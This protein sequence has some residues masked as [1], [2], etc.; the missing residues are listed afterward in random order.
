MTDSFIDKQKLNNFMWQSLAQFILTNRLYI[1]ISL[2]AYTAF[3]GYHAKDAELS[4][5]FMRIVPP[6]DP[7][8]IYFKQFQEMFGEDASVFAIG[9]KDSSI[10][11]YQSFQAF[12]EF[13]Q[14]VANAN[15]IDEVLALPNLVTLKKDVANKKFV[16]HRIFEPF[17]QNQ[18][19]LDSLLAYVDDLGFYDDRL[20][21]KENGA[22]LMLISMEDNFLNSKRRLDVID[23]VR[24]AGDAFVQETGIGI[25]YAGLPYVRG[26]V[27]TK[28]KKE[29]NMFLI[30]S[31]CVTALVFFL[32]FRSF[33][34]VIFSLCVIGMVVISTVGC[35]S[36]LGYRITML[37][38]LLPPILVVIGVPNCIYLI[39]KFHQEFAQHNDKT[40]ALKNVIMKVGVVTLITNTTTAIGFAV[41]VFTKIGVMQEFGLVAT[42]NIFATF[43]ISILFIPAVFSYRPAPQARHMRHLQFYPVKA[44]LAFIDEV[45][46]KRYR[47]AVYMV[48]AALVVFAYIGTLKVQS[49]AYLVDDMPEESD[50]VKDLKFFE[51]NFIGI[52]PL[53]IVVDTGNKRGI[54]NRANLEKIEELEMYL[55]ALEN[56]SEPISLITF[57]KAANQAYFNNNPAEYRLPARRDQAFLQP[58]LRSQ[59]AENRLVQSYVDTAGQIVRV[60]L[61]V[62]DMGSLKMQQLIDNQIR[63]AIDSIFKDTSMDVKVTGTT[64]L[65]IRGTDYLINNLL[66][67]MLIAFGLIALIM[68]GLFRKFR[69]ILISL[70]PNMIP[71]LMTAGL[72]GYLGISL[73]PSTALVF[74][75]T[76]GIAVDDA[77]HFLAKYRQELVNHHFKVVNAISVSIRETGASMLYT[78][79]VLFFGFIIFTAS[80]FGG[81]IALGALTST[82]L[83]IAMLTNIVLLPCLLYSFDMNKEEL[84]FHPFFEH[85]EENFYHEDEDEEINVSKLQVKQ[86][87][88]N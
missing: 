38:G 4:Y 18:Q 86:P 56:V 50:V 45:V 55:S 85:L 60:S 12:A 72:M 57:L 53:E 76:F 20:I 16:P 27:Q 51:E 73:K 8:Y 15:G 5:D 2:F 1:I 35:I 44:F 26:I 42:I 47:V 88:K 63:P 81:T 87:E 69:I 41:L 10:Y 28:V 11:Q 23:D 25:H 9:I 52:M 74:S 68:G 70:I 49:I 29:L 84:K 61:N 31:L 59:E 3:M 64:L 19:E 67:S 62:A 30:I 32:F 46:V 34:P 58:Y 71:L 66:N 24:K 83:L 21:N 14:A 65:F 75:I 80:D 39:N 43:V 13:C 48:S 82:T 6:E 54:R 22:T 7:D 77:I 78:S 40:K 33:S 36:L 17:P 79:V 37:T